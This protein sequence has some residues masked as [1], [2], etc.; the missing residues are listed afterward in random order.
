MLQAI[1][2]KVGSWIVKVLFAFLIISFGV[3]GIGDVFQDQ[4]PRQTIASVG[5]TEIT[6]ETV[7][8]S[9]GLQVDRLRQI[10]G[11][12]FDT[13]AAVRIG[14]L[15]QVV[16]DLVTGALLDR[17]AAGLGIVPPDALIADQIRQQEAFRNPLTGQF[18]RQQFLALLA[19]NNLTEA[20]FVEQVRQGFGRQIVADAITGGVEAPAVL[21]DRLFRFRRETRTA[22]IVTIAA[23]RIA[24]IPVPTEEDLAA[25]YQQHSQAFMAPEYRR[26]SVVGL[27]AAALAN[28][29]SIP[30]PELRDAYQARLDQYRTPE[31]RRFDQVVL[32]RDQQELATRIA[33]AAR[34]GGGDL[35]DAVSS[36][37][38]SPAVI[39]LDWTTAAEMLPAEL[40]QAG[41]ALPEG[42]VSAPVQS[43]FGWHVLA[44][45]EIR[46]ASQRGFEEVRGELETAL[47]LERAYDQLADEANQFDEILAGGAALEDAAERIGLAPVQTPPVA[48]DGA[49]QGDAP[50][51]AIPSPERV[52][53]VAFGLPEGSESH[54]VETPEGDF[55]VVRVDAVVPPALRPL[56]EVRDQVTA[57][58]TAERRAEAAGTLAETVAERLRAG[59][60]AEQVA[61]SIEGA[62]AGITPALQRDGSNRDDLPTG[63]INGLF[64][65]TIGEVTI[66]P[67]GAGGG[68]IVARLTGIDAA[69]PPPEG[70]AEAADPA[71]AALARIR[72]ET[73]QTLSTD[74]VVQFAD[75]LRARYGVEIDRDALARLA[76]RSGA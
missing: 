18:D 58:W 55:F 9:L 29:L 50:M 35:H 46:P 63:L 59:E 26:L 69:A 21:A 16:N 43:P 13:A 51:P 6:A 40:G 14:L 68:Q 22:D 73:A 28:R 39:P 48:Q 34:G 12:E 1:R 17:Q 65:L 64:G 47:K 42:G 36:L 37:G 62:A 49:T 15:D 45:T 11:P 75:A 74:L 24:G 30:E 4:G 72:S 67:A 61:G 56:P 38:A 23:D 10:L 53:A 31:R 41:F 66:A 57:A 76:E 32:G 44:V 33:E 8:R 5:D 27:S 25:Y 7:Q 60:P 52:R 54:L 20:G 19:Q 2:G 71:A 70:V 3:W